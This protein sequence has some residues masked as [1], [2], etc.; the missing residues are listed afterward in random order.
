MLTQSYVPSCSTPKTLGQDSVVQLQ[1]A[2]HRTHSPV[3]GAANMA[4][5]HLCALWG[6]SDPW[7]ELSPGAV[8]WAMALQKHTALLRPCPQRAPACLQS[9]LLCLGL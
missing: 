3:G 1:K 5:S 4:L 2:Q 7:L 8:L 6:W 9:H